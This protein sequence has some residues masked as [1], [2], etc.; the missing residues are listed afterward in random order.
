MFLLFFT[1]FSII[2]VVAMTETDSLV[3]HTYAGTRRESFFISPFVNSATLV[4][5]QLLPFNYAKI[6]FLL[7]S[8][9]DVVCECICFPLKRKAK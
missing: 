1:S 3:L 8:H 5:S 2:M 6:G 9:S 4:S 7:N